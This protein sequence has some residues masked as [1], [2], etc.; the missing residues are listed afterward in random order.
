MGVWINDGFY[1]EKKWIWRVTQVSESVV[2]RAGTSP[3]RVISS[4]A[5]KP[6]ATLAARLSPPPAQRADEH[7]YE[8]HGTPAQAIRVINRHAVVLEPA[9]AHGTLFESDAVTCENGTP[10]LVEIAERDDRHAPCV[11]RCVGII[12][13]RVLPQTGGPHHTRCGVDRGNFISARAFIAGPACRAATE[14]A[15]Y[16]VD[17]VLGLRR[18]LRPHERGV[19]LLVRSV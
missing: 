2:Y 18:C 7:T 3:R 17:R 15:Q 13:T 8:F 11:L 4:R 6:Q 9:A 16:D 14:R 1:G 10:R 19:W 12:T 5:E